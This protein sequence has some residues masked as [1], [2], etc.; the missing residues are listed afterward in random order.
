MHGLT[1]GA[2]YWDPYRPDFWKDPYPVFQRLREAAPLYYNEQYD[3]YA[4]SRFSDVERGL[5]DKDAFSSSRGDI[6]EYIKANTPVP[7]GMFIWEDPPSHTMHRAILSRVFTPK[8]MN[9]LDAKIRDYCARVLDPLVGVD[10]FDFIADLGKQLPMRVISMLLGIPEQDQE[11]VRDQVDAR[12]STEA[13]KPMDVSRGAPTG[14]E[15]EAYID[16]RAKHPSDDL[17]TEMMQVEFQDETGVRRKLTREEILIFVNLIAGA[18]NETT[19]RLIG[20]TGKLLSDHPEQRAELVANPALIPN[21]VEEILR[22]ES[23]GPS[24]ARYVQRDVELYGRT[25]SEGSA[26]LLL[27]ASANRDERRYPDAARFDIHRQGPPHITFGRG[28]HSCLGAALAR[29]EGRVALQELLKR[30]PEWTVDMEN[31]KLQST[32]TVRGWES[33]PAFVGR[34]SAKTVRRNVASTPPAATPA[35]APG[36]EAWELTMTTP[37][38]PQVMTVQIV[39][40]GDSFSGTATG[41]MG[42]QEINGKI[43][44]NTLTWTLSL[45]QPVAIKLSFEATVA[46]NTMSGNVKLGVFG[47][48]PL[49][50]K[51]L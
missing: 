15:F 38:G 9:D 14:E 6:L 13:G 21:A 40:S 17:M 46:G 32:S 3:F 50:G 30:F 12:L 47:N 44:G 35:A 42:V 1:E 29:V 20:W 10:Y 33:L 11:A 31:A 7:K 23:P 28:I 25:V 39:K 37:M 24:V 51:R 22:Y 2:V 8:R 27:V 16:W 45:S 48:A 26:L 4:L 41:E 36:S 5:T 18:G 19:N 49:S 34:N 43:D